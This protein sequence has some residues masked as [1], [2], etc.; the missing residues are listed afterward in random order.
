MKKFTRISLIFV[1]VMA[2][3]GILLM[4]LATVMGAGY[5][6]I[7][8][9]A[10][11]GEFDFGSWHFGDGVYWGSDDRET[12]GGTYEETGDKDIYRY[13]T[14]GIRELDVEIGAAEVV[15]QE[16]TGASEIIVTVKGGSR[17]YYEGGM[18]G[19][20]LEIAYQPKE[21]HL[22][23][24]EAPKIIIEIPG[25]MCFEKLDLDVAASDLDFAIGG[26]VCKEMSLTVGAGT[27]TLSDLE[28]EGELDVEIGAGIAELENVSC[29]SL[30]AECGMGEFIMAGSV[31]GDI[32][33]ECSM[34]SM[35][36]ELEGNESD[37]NY[38]LSCGMG[39]L[40]IN[41]SSYAGIAG[42]KQIKNAGAVG[43]IRLECGMGKLDLEI[44]Q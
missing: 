19:D 34:G 43:T 28:V 18:D 8:G 36:M 17:K 10:R 31:S 12:D 1:A 24:G 22:R 20:S 39:D 35:T 41:G 13:Q 11:N 42:S 25:E 2:G 5:S 32:E 21:T 44:W 38:D 9:M 3:A 6:T 26:M 23:K 30:E 27:V 14:D 33:V 7:K 37:Y 29:G 15:F 4:G 16:G 40:T